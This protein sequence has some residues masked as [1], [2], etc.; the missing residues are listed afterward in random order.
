MR[1]EPAT[2]RQPPTTI[3]ILGIPVHNITFAETIESIDSFIR[4]KTPKQICTVNPEFVMTAQ[5]DEEFKTI[6]A[7]ADLC[8]PDGVGIVWA[9]RW[10]KTPLRER[11][12]GSDLVPM[13]AAEAEQHGWK[14]FFLG[15]G[16]GV[17]SHAAQILRARHP[18]LKIVGTHAGS[19]RPEDDTESIRLIQQAQPDILFVAYGAPAQDKWIQ[20]N[21]ERV[22]IPVMMGVGGSFDFITGVATRAPRWMQAIG[23]EWL[24]RL[25]QQPWRWKRMLALPRFVV[26]VLLQKK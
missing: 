15:A 7:N 11:V 18:N 26:R 13:I 17:A 5:Q 3:H 23:L 12:T 22:G 14:L 25:I 6:L 8:L 19:P 20:R 1:L 2:S 9:A 10:L 16:E 24:H 21:R 4:A